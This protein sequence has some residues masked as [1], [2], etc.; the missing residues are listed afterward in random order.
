MPSYKAGD[1]V[2]VHIG[3][4]YGWWP[5]QVMEPRHVAED[6]RGDVLRLQR[7]GWVLVHCHGDRTFNWFDPLRDV[8]PIVSSYEQ[9]SGQKH[10]S[11]GVK[12]FFKLA[13]EEV[14]ELLAARSNKPS[15]TQ[16][17]PVDF[18]RPETYEHLL[19]EGGSEEPDELQDAAAAAAMQ[20]PEEATAAD[21][22]QAGTGMAL[23]AWLQQ[24]AAMPGAACEELQEE[25]PSAAAAAAM[26]LL[27]SYI[28]NAAVQ[29]HGAGAWAAVKPAAA[30]SGAAK[31]RKKSGKAAAAAAAAVKPQKQAAGAKRKASATASEA[32]AAAGKKAKGN[33]S[34]AAA[35]GKQ[36]NAPCK[37]VVDDAEGE[38]AAALQHM[39]A[40][41]SKPSKKRK[42]SAKSAA[43]AAAAAAA[44][45]RADSGLVGSGAPVSA[46]DPQ[47]QDEHLMKY[48]G[49]VAGAS[50][51]KAAQLLRLAAVS[52]EPITARLTLG[53]AKSIALLL[54]WREAVMA[55]SSCH[56]KASAAG[57]IDVAWRE[58]KA[59]VPA[60]EA[61]FVADLQRWAGERGLEIKLGKVAK[62]ELTLADCY[63]IFK[64][65]ADKGGCKAAVQIRAWAGIARAWNA[66]VLAQGKNVPTNLR[67]AYERHLLQYENHISHGCEVIVKTF[68]GQPASSKQQQQQQQPPAKASCVKQESPEAKQQQQGRVKQE[69]REAEQQQGRVKQEA[70]QA[71]QQHEPAGAAAVKQEQR[72]TA[73]LGQQHS[74]SDGG[75]EA[76]GLT[77]LEAALAAEAEAAAAGNA[78]NLR[79]VVLKFRPQFRLPPM[80][81][82]LRVAQHYERGLEAGN[83]R[84]IHDKAEMHITYT[85]ADQAAAALEGFRGAGARKALRIP[86]SEP[87]IEPPIEVTLLEVQPAAADW[88]TRQ[89]Q[90]QRRGEADRPGSSSSWHG[91]DRERERERDSRH[92][93]PRHLHEQHSSRDREDYRGGG[94]PEHDRYDDR[95]DERYGRHHGPPPAHHP[96]GLPP[97]HHPHALPPP[98]HLQQQQQQHVVPGV[99]EYGLPLHMLP[100]AAAAAAAAATTTATTTTAAAAARWHAWF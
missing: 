88:K 92:S 36:Q 94:G 37:Q 8:E 18:T 62:H 26:R 6:R 51:R 34:A 32:A 46:D 99:A 23:L 5:C 77:G 27:W 3:G 31:P 19:R 59:R 66:K 1:L 4:G 78:A 85:S 93:N 7:P 30:A 82:V 48:G 28:H 60:S 87:P 74:D 52:P 70:R 91:R 25:P 61:A 35:S 50:I 24:T 42:Q 17:F 81:T 39:A 14:Q 41:G 63:S 83:V 95:Y 47:L 21:A 11:P 15:V 76:G 12:K 49:P 20:Y 13:L 58:Y 57:K 10:K 45:G 56:M 100:A 53:Q 98:M 89:Q 22:Q 73:K 33:S 75:G 84:I 29:Q 97:P 43:A 54:R 40:E 90:Q 69:A 86:E 72:E 68:K 55:R 67:S 9:R 64:L 96:P 16:H 38:A 44:D 80:L 71:E 65:V 2:W 79:K